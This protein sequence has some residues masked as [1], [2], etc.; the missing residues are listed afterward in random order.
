[1]LREHFIHRVKSHRAI[2]SQN[3]KVVNWESLLHI[4]EGD[5]DQ[6]LK[7]GVLEVNHLLKERPF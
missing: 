6:P 4:P 3:N 7:A 1:M 5:I 2:P